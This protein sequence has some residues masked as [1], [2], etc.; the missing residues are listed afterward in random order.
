MF[1]AVAFDA[2]FD[3]ARQRVDHRNTDTVQTTGKV[4]T[5]VGEFSAG[6]Q[7]GHDHFNAGDFF[8]RV[9]INRHTA[10]VVFDRQ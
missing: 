2:H 5:L 4:I 3:F 1:F 9:N 7:L 10:T 6:V 8:F